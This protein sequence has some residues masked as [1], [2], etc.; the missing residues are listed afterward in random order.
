MNNVAN[1]TFHFLSEIS[2]ENTYSLLFP[3]A[4]AGLAIVWLYEQ[5]QNGTFPQNG[6]KEKDIHEALRTVNPTI[7][8]DKTRHPREHY[9]ALISNLLEYFLRYDEERQ[10]YSFKEYAYVFCRQAH[11][12]LKASFSPTKIEKICFALHEKLKQSK[13]LDA[14]LDWSRIDFDAFKPQLKSQLDFLD[15]QIDQS[16]ASLR[17]NKKL[18]LQEG[19]ILETLRQI[20]E[21]F[22]LIRAQNKELRTAFRE[23]E[24]IRRLME[25]NASA[26]DNAEV[27]ARVHEAITFFQEMRR[28]L[29]IIDKR[30]DRIQP[31]IRQL[32]SNLNKPLFNTWV[33]RFL[34]HLVE[35]S[36]EVIDGSK[37]TIR[38]PGNIPSLSV[39]QLKQDLAI[40]ERKTDLF[41]VKPKKRLLITE[42]PEVKASVFA[43][44]QDRL[45]QQDEISHWVDVLQKEVD[46]HEQLRLSDYFFQIAKPDDP[47][48]L[49]LAIAVIY[50]AVGFFERQEQYTVSIDPGKIIHNTAF[51]TS[52]WEIIIRRKT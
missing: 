52:L 11:D 23:I 32:F 34:Y 33:E 20:D 28:T 48:T 35:N 47:R 16:V 45:N 37:K 44:F 36:T 43:S 46:M 41:P 22:E 39:F 42:T 3:E 10:E 25:S 30:L 1:H 31:K 6:F 24:Q 51:K 21:R 12:I 29:S 5:M 40:V 49:T 13:D 2:K 7:E 9:N 38:L 26:Y 50:R 27:D 18:S 19:T 4:K 17:E 8:S 14:F 15:R